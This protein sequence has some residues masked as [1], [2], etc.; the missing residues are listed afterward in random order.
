MV[1]AG[2]WLLPPA[3]ES[4]GRRSG[5][6]LEAIHPAHRG[7]MGLQ[8]REGRTG[9]S[10]RVASEGGPRAVPRAHLL[11]GVCHVE[12][13]GRL[14]ERRRSGGCATHAPLRVR[15]D[16]E[17]RRRPAGGV[18]RWHSHHGALAPRDGARGRA[19]D[20]TAQARADT[21]QEAQAARQPYANVVKTL[22]LDS[23]ESRALRSQVRNL[24]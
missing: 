11:P 16:Q 10:A 15:E 2:R 12:D 20:A 6:A 13:A 23:R 3:D 1:A 8:D 17:R 14:D 21:S 18:S 9:D 22:T 5:H 4:H 7:G 19:E 24:G